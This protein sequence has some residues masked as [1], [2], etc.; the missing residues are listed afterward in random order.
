MQPLGDP[1]D[2][3]V[4]DLEFR[5]VST[6]ESLVFRPEPFGDLAYREVGRLFFP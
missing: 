3:Q 5:E 2:E 1:I 6:R 4:K